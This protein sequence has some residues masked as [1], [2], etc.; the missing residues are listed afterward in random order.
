VEIA[1]SQAATLTLQLATVAARQTVMAGDFEGVDQ[2]VATLSVETERFAE[3]LDALSAAAA[4]FERFLDGMRALLTS[5]EGTPAAATSTPTASP[6]PTETPEAAGS[7]TR[8]TSTP[9]PTRTP[10][11]SATP[12]S[13]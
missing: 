7:A 3:E 11:P 6:A 10:R 2:A 8:P 9:I 12:F 5:L 13:P 4:G 1:R